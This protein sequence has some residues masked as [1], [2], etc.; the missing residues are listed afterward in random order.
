MKVHVESVFGCTPEKA[1]SEVQKSALLLEVARPLVFIRPLRGERLP[2]RW[3]QDATVGCKSY[4]FGI[5]PLGKRII[6][7]ERVD[8]TSREIQT[9]EHDKLIHK[10]DHLIRV[11]TT[12]DGQVQ[13][14]DEVEI[15][16]GPLTPLV[17]LFVWFY[18]H[19]HRRWRSVAKRL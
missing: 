13:Y 4:L 5:L 11:R 3:Q 1:W 9:R 17:W 7:F 15:D 6:F 8:P 14:S 18:R 12:E 2:E 10:W 16:A 19:R